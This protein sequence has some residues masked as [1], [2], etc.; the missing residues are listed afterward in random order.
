[1]AEKNRKLAPATLL[2]LLSIAA[3]ATAAVTI[4]NITEWSIKAVKPP[5]VKEKGLDCDNC[6]VQVTTRQ[7]NDG[8]NRTVITIKGFR[9]DI[10]NYTSVIKVCHRGS[11]YVACTG[12]DC[13]AW[14]NRLNVKLVYK[15]LLEG[16]QW[17]DYIRYIKLNIDG[18]STPLTIDKNTQ[19]GAESGAVTLNEGN[20]VNVSAELLIDA[21]IR[22]DNLC[23]DLTSLEIDVVATKP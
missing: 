2:I 5:I 1:M 11:S 12:E 16:S 6:A 3:F 19:V 17:N 22:D 10:V 14:D 13:S 20:C 23:Q 4:T 15:G 21:S 7:E 18:S 9:G 8:T